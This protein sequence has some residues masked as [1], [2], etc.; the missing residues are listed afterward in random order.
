MPNYTL[1]KLDGGSIGKERADLMM[2]RFRDKHPGKEV[3]IA[4]FIGTDNIT[5]ILGQ[6]E[7]VGLRVYF[8]YGD[9][10]QLD[11]FFVGARAD[12]TNIGPIGSNGGTP[13]IMSDQTMPCPPYCG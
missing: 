1:S 13:G 2:Q 10:G 11:V 6:G 12:G 9:D 3:V 4:R 5:N 7:C 8:G